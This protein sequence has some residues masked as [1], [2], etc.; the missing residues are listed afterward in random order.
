MAGNYYESV[1]INIWGRQEQSAGTDAF[2]A[3]FDRLVRGCAHV[4][5][6]G[7]FL[8]PRDGVELLLDLLGHHW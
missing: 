4:A 2:A 8:V 5:D 3:E 7:D 1:E 6:L